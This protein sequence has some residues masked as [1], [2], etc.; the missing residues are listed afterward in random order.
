MN[1]VDELDK[2]LIILLEKLYL[3][4]RYSRLISG[5]LTLQEYLYFLTQTYHYVIS[6]PK[7]LLAV[8][9]QLER[10]SDLAYQKIR[11]RFLEHAKE[12]KGHHFWILNDVKALGY[13]PEFVKNSIPSPAISAYNAYS[14]FIATSNNPIGIFGQAYI[15]EGLSEKIGPIILKNLTEKSKIPNIT[16]SMSFIKSHVEAD[17]GH[18]ESLKNVLRTILDEDDEYAIS[19]CAEVVAQQY[20]H[21]FH[22][23]EKMDKSCR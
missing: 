11:N 16:K 4:P 18:I 8:A 19:L 10:H 22:Y 7:T 2:T 12:E 21:F 14:Y 23:L 3:D 5:E 1:L 9:R 17:V 15:L 20:T 13:N 6:T